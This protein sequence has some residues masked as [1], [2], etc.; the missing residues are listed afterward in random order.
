L[1][2]TGQVSDGSSLLPP[3]AILPAGQRPS[4]ATCFSLPYSLAR[5]TP[6]VP[7]NPGPRRPSPPPSFRPISLR[8][9]PLADWS[10]WPRKTGPFPSRRR[11]VS[12]VSTLAVGTALVDASTLATGFASS[13][14]CGSVDTD[15][16]QPPAANAARRATTQVA[17]LDLELRAAVLPMWVSRFILHHPSQ[18]LSS[19][20]WRAVRTSLEC[21]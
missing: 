1:L 5:D 18:A 6:P 9:Q 12:G 8:D 16:E 2:P 13:A 7:S 4:N 19:W 11:H 10:P 20:D 3:E 15:E 21:E 14:G 17:A